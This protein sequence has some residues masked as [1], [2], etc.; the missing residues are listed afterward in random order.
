MSAPFICD[1]PRCQR[2]ELPALCTKWRFDCFEGEFRKIVSDFRMYGD[3]SIHEWGDT[4]KFYAKLFGPKGF[5]TIEDFRPKLGG[6]RVCVRLRPG[7]GATG[8]AEWLEFYPLKPSDGSLSS[9]VAHAC[10]LAGIE[11]RSDA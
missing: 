11:K 5:V 10:E 1:T 9:A 3:W 4:G 6:Y 8:E 2:A 7:F